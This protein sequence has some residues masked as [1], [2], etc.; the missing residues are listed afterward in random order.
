MPRPSSVCGGVCHLCFHTCRVLMV[1]QNG[2]TALLWQDR[3][4][5]FSINVIQLL[6]Y[7]GTW[8]TSKVLFPPSQAHKIILARPPQTLLYHPCMPAGHWGMPRPWHQPKQLPHHTPSMGSRSQLPS[9]KSPLL[10]AELM[11]QCRTLRSH[12]CSQENC[13]PQKKQSQSTLTQQLWQQ[14]A[15]L[16]KSRAQSE[17]RLPPLPLQPPSEPQNIWFKPDTKDDSEISLLFKIA[18]DTNFQI[19]QLPKSSHPLHF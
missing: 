4:S 19:W 8:G 16:L 18:Q 6:I 7:G 9:W 12:W 13:F 10:H 3:I 5:V 17:Q 15:P 2:H 14:K 1:T 11:R